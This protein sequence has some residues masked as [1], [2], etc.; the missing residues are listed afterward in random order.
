MKELVGNDIKLVI[1]D[2]GKDPT[3]SMKI[4]NYHGLAVDYYQHK[5]GVKGFIHSKRGLRKVL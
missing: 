3:L 1:E 4:R 2:F 5:L